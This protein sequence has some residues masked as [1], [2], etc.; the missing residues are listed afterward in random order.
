[1]INEMEAARHA[2]ERGAILGA[3]QQNYGAEMTSVR[4]L[5]RALDALGHAMRPIGLQF[6]LT[7]LT[8][9]GYIRIW[10]AR[11]LPGYRSDRAN[12]ERGDEIVF[13][14]LMPKGLRLI[15]GL[16]EADPGVSF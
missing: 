5:G 7:Y 15:D 2:Q 16:V 1:M 13:A 12:D 9:C 8:D 14:K 6:A 10:R 4:T 11:D 3:L